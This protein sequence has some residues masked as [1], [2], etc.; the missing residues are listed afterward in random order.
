MQAF[1]QCHDDVL[2]REI[3]S[4]AIETTDVWTQYPSVGTSTVNGN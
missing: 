1:V 3:Q 2:D 4:E